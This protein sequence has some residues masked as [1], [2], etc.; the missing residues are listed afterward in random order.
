M[1]NN[2]VFQKISNMVVSDI[3]EDRKAPYTQDEVMNMFGGF[4][5]ADR[6]LSPIT[7]HSILETAKCIDHIADILNGL[8]GKEVTPNNLVFF[9]DELSKEPISNI[10][11]MQ[12]LIDIVANKEDA[13]S[14]PLGGQPAFNELVAILLANI[15]GLGES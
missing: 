14:N 1:Q 3:N 12:D 8:T 9:G 11:S 10:N 4:G 2:P 13:L 15:A 6:V 7:Q 5:K